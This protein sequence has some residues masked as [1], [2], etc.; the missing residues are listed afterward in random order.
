LIQIKKQD[1]FD[2]VFRKKF[3]KHQKKIRKKVK[4]LTLLTD[5]TNFQDNPS[6]LKVRMT[7]PTWSK[8]RVELRADPWPS[9]SARGW[10]FSPTIPSSSFLSI[11]YHYRNSIEAAH[12][13]RH[14]SPKKS[15]NT[16]PKIEFC[17]GIGFVDTHLALKPGIVDFSSYCRSDL[18]GEET[19]M[20]LPFRNPGRAESV[21]GPKWTRIGWVSIPEHLCEKQKKSTYV[22]LLLFLFF[23]STSFAK[24]V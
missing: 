17:C 19:N 10:E 14:L 15:R 16:K 3:T 9:H 18:W 2:K 7:C 8:K 21:K 6:E 23:F 1:Q 13:Q 20:A 24:G 11:W 4:E 22:C 5:W 12:S